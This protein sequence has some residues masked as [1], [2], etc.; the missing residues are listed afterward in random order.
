MKLS[1][2]LPIFNESLRFKTG[3]KIAL[4]YLQKQSYSWEIIIVDDGSNNTNISGLDLINSTKV[5]LL[6]T[7]HNFGKGHAIR[8]G[9]DAAVGEYI[10][11]SDI[12]FSVPITY[13]PQ[14]LSALNKFDVAIGSRRLAG[15][16]IAQHQHFL[17]EF[18]GQGFTKLSNLILGLNH[19]D[20][21]CGFKAFRASVAKGLF[22]RQHLNRWAFD[23]EILF[24]AKKVG[25]TI[26]EIPVTWHNDPLTKVNLFKDTLTSLISLFQIR[27]IHL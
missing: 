5:K 27:L 19:S 15:S 8:L 3:L 25:Y 4:N 21:T 24:L 22:F 11:F 16:V 13:L 12:D 9:I 14:F 20:L 23:P 17:R 10:V 26:T 18:L 6:R 1:L 2:I 7:A